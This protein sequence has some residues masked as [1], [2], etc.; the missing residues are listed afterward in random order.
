MS[1]IKDGTGNGYLAR[2]NSFNRL[3][4]SA[5]SS[6]R[7]YYESRDRGAA[8]GITT[9]QLT[10][11]TTG[12]KILYIKNNSSTQNMAIADVRVEKR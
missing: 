4:V 11:T 9:P 3:D 10:V 6:P 7:V 1:E 12:G 2:V 5:S 8:F